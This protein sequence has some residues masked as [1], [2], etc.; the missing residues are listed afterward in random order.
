MSADGVERAGGRSNLRPLV[1]EAL[2]R[3]GA[4]KGESRRWMDVVS[5]EGFFGYFL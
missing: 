3:A 1:Q 2:G 4:G 5:G